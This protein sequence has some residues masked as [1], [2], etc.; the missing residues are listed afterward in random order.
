MQAA[1]DAAVATCLSGHE[2]CSFG[3]MTPRSGYW[4]ADV[5]CELNHGG[6]CTWC[7]AEATTGFAGWGADGWSLWQVPAC[8]A[9]GAE[10]AAGHPE[11]TRGTELKPEPSWQELP[12]GLDSFARGVAEDYSQ[13]MENALLYGDGPRQDG[14]EFTGLDEVMGDAM[15][16]GSVVPW[17]S[18]SDGDLVR[19]LLSPGWFIA[20]PERTRGEVKAAVSAAFPH[21]YIFHWKE[22]P[23][24]W[25]DWWWDGSVECCYLST[26]GPYMVAILKEPTGGGQ[27]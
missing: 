15:G 2:G 27:R 9:H 23:R 26:H 12:D 20:D 14:P 7:P 10:W 22:R 25:P 21:V 13:G 4:L 6:T 3:G 18:D 5:D 11:W 16:G 1:W 24:N 17:R 8:A 19:A